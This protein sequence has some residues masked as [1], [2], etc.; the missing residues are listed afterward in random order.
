MKWST[1]GNGY[2][3]TAFFV[4]KFEISQNFKSVLRTFLRMR[5]D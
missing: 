3:G 4:D 5:V 1:M 2:H